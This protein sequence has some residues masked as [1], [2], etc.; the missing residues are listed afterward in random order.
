MYDW[1]IAPAEE[2]VRDSEAL[3]TQERRVIANCELRIANWF[4]FWVINGVVKYTNIRYIP[5][6]NTWYKY[7]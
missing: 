2:R 1:R 6:S 4:Y 3:A 7:L 5:V